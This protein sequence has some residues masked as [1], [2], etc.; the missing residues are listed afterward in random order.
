M[1]NIKLKKRQIDL[2]TLNMFQA[3]TKLLFWASHNSSPKKN[4]CSLYSHYITFLPLL[5]SWGGVICEDRNYGQQP[6]RL[7]S[8]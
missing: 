6:K 1:Q 7:H 3:P 5:E 8:P 2:A 4:G